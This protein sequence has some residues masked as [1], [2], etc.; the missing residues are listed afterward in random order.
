MR[1]LKWVRQLRYRR[2]PLIVWD[3]DRRNY[4]ILLVAAD[5][6]AQLRQT[7]S[8]RSQHNFSAQVRFRPAFSQLLFICVKT[9][10]IKNLERTCYYQKYSR[11]VYLHYKRTKDYQI[12]FGIIILGDQYPNLSQ[13]P[14]GCCG[15][16]AMRYSAA[17]GR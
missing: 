9:E 3:G 17:R 5:L 14:A 11:I 4:F 13:V 16:C 6:S 1:S 2:F 10:P 12:I 15:T 7:L 8:L